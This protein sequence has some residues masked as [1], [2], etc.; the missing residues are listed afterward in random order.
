MKPNF[1][2][3]SSGRKGLIIKLFLLLSALACSA[4]KAQSKY[5][6]ESFSVGVGARGL[7]M[8]SAYHT[9]ATGAE[10]LYWNPAGLAGTDP[11]AN[12]HL[13]FMHSERFSGEVDYNFIGYA[14]RLP[15]KH[16]RNVIG[17][18]LIHLGVGGIPIVTR[19][20]DPDRELGPDNRPVIDR[21]SSKND[22]ALLAGLGRQFRGNC[23][24]G[25]NVKVLYLSQEGA[26]ASGFGFDIGAVFP[27]TLKVIRLL[28]SLSARDV[29]TSFLAYS[30]G[31][32][33][34]IKPWI[35]AGLALAEGFKLPGGSLS[36]ALEVSI[37]LERRRK[38]YRSDFD[39]LM[40][41]LHFGF[42]YTLYR[43]M[44][45]R[46]GLD[47]KH[48]AFGAGIF[49]RSLAL[50]YAWIGHRDLD[51]THRISLGYFF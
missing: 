18:G 51:Q 9:L 10:A 38:N 30:T 15:G 37:P 49:V 43:R 23:Y 45:L 22:F 4:L 11:E 13:A 46:G 40:S 25:A 19:L 35:S 7:G 31:K 6:G 1:F 8:G 2:S 24:L 36:G 39:Y 48:P 44:F 26:S 28:S 47:E 21:Y 17:V 41:L 16:H 32:R 3:G 50:D 14:R 20:E 27:L 29:T 34:Y 42:E 5:A 33:E 12:N